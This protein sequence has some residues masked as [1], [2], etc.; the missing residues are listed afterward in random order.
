MAMFTVKTLLW[1]LF[2]TLYL[3]PLWSGKRL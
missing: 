1:L 3:S 2:L